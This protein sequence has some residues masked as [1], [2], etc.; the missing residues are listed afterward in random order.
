MD[1]LPDLADKDA[2]LNLRGNWIVEMS[3]LS[4]LY[5]SQLETA[6]AFVT[7]DVDKVRPPYGRRRIDLPRQCVF[8]GTT[9]SKDYL[10][11]PT[12]NRRYWPVA[13]SKLD[14][15]ALERD[16]LQLLA[17]AK[18]M[19]DFAMEPLWLEGRSKRQAEK[20]QELRRIED[21]SD[22]MVEK[23]LAFLNTPQKDRSIED[24]QSVS[25]DELFDIGPFS[26]FTKTRNNR[27]MAARVLRHAGYR[28]MHTR[29]GKRWV[30]VKRKNPITEIA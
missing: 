20:I 24:V 8:I 30:A 6:K 15:A 4:A 14:F 18:F 26:T 23:F 1:G 3:E 27:I 9:N 21:E 5:L 16:R 19:Y 10:M 12:G 17:E 13:V 25:L 7:R 28:K 29:E 2:A 22:S 11:D